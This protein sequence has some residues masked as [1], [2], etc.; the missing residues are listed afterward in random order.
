M[1]ERLTMP[2]RLLALIACALPLLLSTGC[3]EPET[4]ARAAG[5]TT[6]FDRALHDALPEDVRSSGELR[7]ATDASY[8]PASLFAED[9]RTIIG[10]EPDL[11]AAIGRVLGVRLRFEQANFSQM[12]S[13]ITHDRTDLVMSAMTDTA[14]R[15]KRADFVNY[16]S[17]GTAII[18]QRGNPAGIS[19]LAGLCG[20]RVAVEDG[21]I[22]VDL[23]ARSQNRCDDRPIVVRTYDTNADA[24]VQLRT[25]RAAAVLTDYPPAAHLAT[26]PKTRARFQLASTAQYEPGLYGIAVARD[27]PQ[28]RDAVRGAL[29]RV[30]R[31]GE[32]E[33]ILERWGVADGGVRESSINAGVH[34]SGG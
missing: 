2:R 27:R 13:D 25:G 12:L 3:T 23:L 8:A 22:Q 6:P 4:A 15:E 31:S 1:T 21:T 10:F 11:G 33:T 20:Q 28:L 34:A 17:A 16:F 30:I 14:A 32:Y 24:L 18:V 5:P 26:D 19:D 9:G 7:V 29:D